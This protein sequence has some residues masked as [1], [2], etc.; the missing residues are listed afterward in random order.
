M[1]FG[2]NAR[3]LAEGNERRAL[4][5]IDQNGQHFIRM[6]PMT[7]QYFDPSQENF[8]DLVEQAP[9]WLEVKEDMFNKYIQH[10]RRPSILGFHK[11]LQSDLEH[12]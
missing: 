5:R 7:N 9:I 10:L 4:A 8:T 1:L 11:I 2:I 12:I 3:E 6:N